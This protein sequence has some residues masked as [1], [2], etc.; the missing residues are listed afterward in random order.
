MIRKLR[1][2]LISAAMISLFIVITI[3]IGIVNILNY[4]G[5]V[6]DADGILTIL[7]DNNGR[8]PQQNMNTDIAKQS[9]EEA[10]PGLSPDTPDSE[11]DSI[12]N[13]SDVTQAEPPKRNNNPRLQS[14]ELPYESR[15]FSVLLDENGTVLS[16][17]TG[18]IAAVNSSEAGE[19][20]KEIFQSGKRTGFFSAY[21]YLRTETDSDNHTRIIFLD[22]SRSLNSF[23]NVLLI[24]CGVSGLGLMMVLGL[25][26]L[27]SKHI[28]KP[29][30]ENYEKQKRFITDAGHEIKT[31]ITIINADTEILEMDTGPNEWIDDIRIQTE[32]LSKLTKDLIYLARMEEGEHQTQMIDF[33]LSEVI[34]ETAASFQALARTESKQFALQ[35]QPMLSFYGDEDNIRKLTSILLDNALKYSDENGFIQLNLEKKGKYIQLLVV[36][37]TRDALNREQLTHLFDRFYRMDTSRNSETGGYGIGLSIA[38]AVVQMHKGK[39]SATAVND[40]KIQLSVLLPI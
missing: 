5:I 27:L 6:Q 20:A 2:K 23:R 14:P 8:F 10:A 21:R 1:F 31:P 18:K 35:I 30:S 33:P 37:T 25:M 19:Y 3:I 40:H 39:I 13:A 24:S 15:F 4:H 29:F 36:N 11:S 16:T 9:S 34:S 38:Q 22:C 12:E 17:D 7:Q 26:I 28:I 32:R